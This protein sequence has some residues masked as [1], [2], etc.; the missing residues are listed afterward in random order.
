MAVFEGPTEAFLT[1]YRLERPNESV[2]TLLLEGR[3]SSTFPVCLIVLPALI[4]TAVRQPSAATL[5]REISTAV[6]G[7]QRQHR[8][9]T[10]VDPSLR[11]LD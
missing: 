1:C 8:V 5:C 4:G 10:G 7:L 6:S 9:P 3:L 2:R 11:D